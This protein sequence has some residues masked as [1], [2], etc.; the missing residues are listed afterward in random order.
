MSENEY[1][2]EY[3]QGYGGRRDRNQTKSAA[4]VN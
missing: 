2:E 1:I 4:K 3:L